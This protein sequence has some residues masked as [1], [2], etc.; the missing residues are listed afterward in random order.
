MEKYPPGKG[1]WCICEILHAPQR[2]SQTSSFR[3]PPS[4]PE[5]RLP[6]ATVCKTMNY[7]MVGARATPPPAHTYIQTCI[8][9]RIHARARTRAHTPSNFKS[10]KF[11]H[12]KVFLKLFY[13]IILLLAISTPG[14]SR[15]LF[16]RV[17]L[18]SGI[19]FFFF[20]KKKS[21]KRRNN[22][23]QRPQRRKQIKSETPI[24]KQTIKQIFG[25]SK[26]REQKQPE[27]I[28]ESANRQSLQSK[29]ALAPFLADG[30][31]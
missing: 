24:A 5:T 8:R 9:K 13:S 31:E 2:L 12:A 1:Q 26:H 6:R 23:E 29:A 14:S 16:L 11:K 18:C 7:S 4:P 17:F 22:S 19:L 3:I 28:T 30:F 25:K 27:Q 10:A 15:S 20:F 21:K